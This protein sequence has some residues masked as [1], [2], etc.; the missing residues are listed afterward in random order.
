MIQKLKQAV[1]TNPLAAWREMRAT[2]EEFKQ[3]RKDHA[4]Y[5]DLKTRSE[6]ANR[7]LLV[8]LGVVYIVGATAIAIAAA[9]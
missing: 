7:T 1:S 6:T 2:G 8:W 5:D 9:F 3:Y 4:D